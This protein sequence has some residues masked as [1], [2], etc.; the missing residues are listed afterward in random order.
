[1]DDNVSNRANPFGHG[2]QSVQPPRS[3]TAPDARNQIEL[4]L[5]GSRIICIL[6]DCVQR[7]SLIQPGVSAVFESLKARGLLDRRGKQTEARI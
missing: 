3:E 2:A 5:V 6:L 1:M 4:F 7:L